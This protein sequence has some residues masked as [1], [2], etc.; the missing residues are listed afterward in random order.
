MERTY[1]MRCHTS[2]LCKGTYCNK[3]IFTCAICAP[4]I[5]HWHPHTATRIQQVP[6]LLVFWVSP[7]VIV[8]IAQMIAQVCLLLCWPENQLRSYSSWCKLI[9]VLNQSCLRDIQLR[10]DRKKVHGYQVMIRLSQISC[11]VFVG[12]YRRAQL[13]GYMWFT[14]LEFTWFATCW[15]TQGRVNSRR[16]TGDTRDLYLRRSL[17]AGAEPSNNAT[18]HLGP[19]NQGAEDILGGKEYMDQSTKDKL[20]ESFSDDRYKQIFLK[21]L[22]RVCYVEM[23]FSLIVA[24]HFLCKRAWFNTVP[25]SITAICTNNGHLGPAN[26]CPWKLDKNVEEGLP[27]DCAGVAHQDTG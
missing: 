26:Y 19:T 27:E 18:H 8:S 7:T 15:A 6:M 12:C 10:K 25:T 5:E 1:H 9:G 23:S 2:S 21:G 11:Q 22:F 17:T 3:G 13:G 16:V 20:Q 4:K 24:R 14:A